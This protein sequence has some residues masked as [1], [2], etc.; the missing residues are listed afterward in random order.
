MFSHRRAGLDELLRQTLAHAATAPFYADSWRQHWRKITRARDLA[1]HLPLLHKPEAAEHQEALIVPGVEPEPI[2]HASGIVSSATTR[3][4]RPLRVLR[5]ASEVMRPAPRQGPRRGRGSR[6]LSR[7]LELYSPS[8]GLRDAGS[9]RILLPAVAHL[10]TVEVLHDLLSGQAPAVRYLVVPLP[11]LKWITVALQQRGHDRAPYNLRAIGTTGYPLTAHAR[12]WLGPF[13]RVRL[14]DNYSLSEL[15]GYALECRHCGFFHWQGSPMLFELVDP[16]TG[17]ATRGKLGE[18]VATTL[19]PARP[20]MPLI[21]YATGDVV[22]RG[23]VC[24]RENKRGL[25]FRGRQPHSLTRIVDGQT[26]YL[27]LSRDLLEVTEALPDIAM[28]PH[29]AERLGLVPGADLG[30]PKARIDAGR[31]L[32]EVELRYDPARYPHRAQ[33]VRRQLLAVCLRRPHPDVVLHRPG[34]LDVQRLARE[35]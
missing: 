16:A 11:T 9:D 21:R 2:A 28:Q 5:A 18:L 8:H 6:R 3:T 29:P 32:L 15:P 23:P 1:Q 22:E 27:L 25:R 19:L 31:N 33:E 34:S 24:Q 20:R 10:N 30:V 4:G 17:M 14:F 35:L 12:S 7:T 13:W 26:R